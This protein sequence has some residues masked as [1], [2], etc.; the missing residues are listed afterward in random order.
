[1]SDATTIVYEKT[2][3]NFPSIHY[4]LAGH[5]WNSCEKDDNENCKKQPIQINTH[6]YSSS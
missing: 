4:T 3:N 2:D 1:M 5:H 6:L